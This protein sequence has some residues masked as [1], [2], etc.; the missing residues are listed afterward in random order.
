MLKNPNL[1][2]YLNEEPTKGILRIYNLQSDKSLL[3]KSENIIE[4]SKN[5][6]FQLD[7]GLYS[8]SQLQTDYSEIGLELFAI[9]P[10]CFL[11]EDESLDKLLEK[12]IDN[13]IKNNID[14]YN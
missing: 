4:D 5:I 10:I 3:L 8:N 12:T 11:K 1:S 2:H 14:L 9:E 13:Y 7:L 6:R